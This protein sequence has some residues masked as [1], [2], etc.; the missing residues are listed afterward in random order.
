[1]TDK[2]DVGLT[3]DDVVVTQ[4]Q[5][6]GNNMKLGAISERSFPVIVEATG[7]IDVPP[8]NKAMVSS[9]VNGYVK[10]TPLL[11]GDTVKK[12]QFL[13]SL[14]N[15]EFVQIQQDYIEAMEQSTFLKSEYERQK[16]LMAENITSEK[17]IF[18]SRK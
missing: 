2:T 13:V 1:M 6:D 11:I 5:L 18:G 8:E 10:Q 15:P 4:I 3:P 17:K 9:F 14:E 7:T 12:G 16:T